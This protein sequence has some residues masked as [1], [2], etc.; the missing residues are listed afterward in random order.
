MAT[1]KK[2]LPLVSA[3]ISFYSK[4]RNNPASY[5]VLK[6]LFQSSTGCCL[7]FATSGCVYWNRDVLWGR[8][9]VGVGRGGGRGSCASPPVWGGGVQVCN[10]RPP[11]EG[12]VH[13]PKCHLSPPPPCIYISFPPG[14]LIYIPSNFFYLFLLI[15][16]LFLLL[17]PA[18]FQDWVYISCV[19]SGLFSSL[20]LLPFICL[21]CCFNRFF[22]LCFHVFAISFLRFPFPYL[23]NCCLSLSVSW[24]LTCH[25]SSLSLCFSHICCLSRSIFLGGQKLGFYLFSH[26]FSKLEGVKAFLLCWNKI[27]IRPHLPSNHFLVFNFSPIILVAV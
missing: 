9:E 18:S 24:L 1:K 23:F 27:F 7:G 25:C 17:V 10:V 8:E 6:Q 16:C 21:R 14:M 3:A 13:L 19:H 20:N 11:R 15:C 12:R 22:P 5:F 2:V 4:Q 26:K